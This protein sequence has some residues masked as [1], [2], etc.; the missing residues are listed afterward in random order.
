M[1]EG[2]S[3]VQSVHALKY[4]TKK[5]KFALINYERFNIIKYT[6]GY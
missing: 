1:D 5:S 4:Q 2:G 3:N 6:I